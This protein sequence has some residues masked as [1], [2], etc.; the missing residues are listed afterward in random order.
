LFA[1]YLPA[2]S[3]GLQHKGMDGVWGNRWFWRVL[4]G[5]FGLGIAWYESQT[6]GDVEIFLFAAADLFDGINP[7]GQLYHDWFHYYYDLLFASLIYPLTLLPLRLAKFLWIVLLELAMLRSWTIV[8]AWLPSRGER[9]KGLRLERFMLL[10]FSWNMWVVNLHLQQL[11]PLV[12]WV[13]L[14][15][16]QLG[17]RPWKAALVGLGMATKVIPIAAFPVWFFRKE[18]TKSSIAIAAFLGAMVL[19][20]AWIGGE[21]ANEL[22]ESRWALL[23]PS[24]L[25]HTFDL[26]E[27]ASHSLT[28]W[29]PTLTHAE[30]R[31]NHTRPWRRHVV[32]LDRD[33]VHLLTRLAQALGLLSVFLFFTSRLFAP[34]RNAGY[35]WSAVLAV[36]PVVFPHQ[37]VYAFLM[38]FPAMAWVV[39]QGWFGRGPAPSTSWKALTL[40]A[41]ILMSLHFYFGAHRD[42]FN[43]YK[44]LTMGAVLLLV[45]LWLV[46]PE[47]ARPALQG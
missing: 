3:R 19:P 28:A 30:A 34:A 1:F 32:D 15:A 2:M 46:K 42:V 47:G 36:V 17:A 40:V 11:T 25:E 38:A 21:R 27:E 41:L 8:E 12:L 44:L 18:W 13:I 39:R 22:V 45:S 10:V 26:A 9:A 5:V 33:T 14:E 43:H 35:E 20:V 16:V 24:N 7:Y 23:N 31:G 37:A 6:P 4:L 29:I